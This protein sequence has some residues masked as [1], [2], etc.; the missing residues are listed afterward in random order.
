VIKKSFTLL[1]SLL[2]LQISCQDTTVPKDARRSSGT[3]NGATSGTGNQSVVLGKVLSLRWDP[4]T[5]TATEY[6]IFGLTEEKNAGGTEFASLTVSAANK[7][8]P[9]ADV[10]LGRT[11][12]PKTGKICFYIVA[13]NNGA[14]SPASTPAC[15]TL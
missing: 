4:S 14:M 6:H 15:T 3:T 13:E 12:L 8:A 1:I 5:G 2:A 9:S 7:A 11:S 10:D